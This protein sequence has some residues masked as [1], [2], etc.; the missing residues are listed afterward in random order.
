MALTANRDLIKKLIGLFAAK[1]IKDH[2][3]QNGNLSDVIEEVS[4]GSTD[5]ILSLVRTYHSTTKQNIYLFK[6]NR[7]FRSESDMN[8]FPLN[9]NDSST[10]GNKRYYYL[11]PETTFSVYLSNPVEMQPLSFLQPVV[12]EIENQTL[13]ISFTKLQKD[14][15]SYFQRDR[16]P[17]LAGETNIESETLSIIIDHFA[18]TIG[19]ETNDFN[20]GIKSLWA[21]DILDC[22]KIRYMDPH[23]TILIT[24]NDTL[25]FKQQYPEKYTEMQHAPIAASVWKFREAGEDGSVLDTFA[26]DPTAGTISINKY[27]DNTNQT[28]Y[29]INRILGQN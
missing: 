9:I 27:S 18:A 1:F 28:A 24:M 5:S 25:T 2:F 29:V 13:I 11:Y 22:H 16:N 26:C 21:D 17:K 15:K 3:N 10:S 8:D 6:L 19:I 23:S 12:L 4:S 14:V 7:N 20:A